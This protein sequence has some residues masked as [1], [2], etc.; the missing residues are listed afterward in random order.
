MSMAKREYFELSMEPE[1][2]NDAKRAYSMILE[3]GDR[4]RTIT[5][6]EV[7]ELIA[8]AIDMHVHAFPDPEID[9]GWDQIQVAR[10]ATDAGMGGVVFKA[11][12]F[13][14]A[15]TAP[16]V[17]QAVDE[18]ARSIGKEPAKV[19]GGIVLNYY[20]GG[21]NPAA[22]EMA[23]KI[24]AKV[25]WLPSH[26][27]AHHRRVMGQTGGICL[28]DDH[29]E[30][31]P[32]LKEILAMVAEHDLILDP[33]HAGTKER[34]VVI[35]AAKKA[36]VKRFIVTH[37]DW[38]VTKATIEEQAEMGRM[39][40]FMGLFMYGAVP[41]FNNPHCDPMEMIRIIKQVTPER[42]VVATDLGTAVNVHPV[43][44]MRLFI[45]ILLAC[46][47]SKPDITRMIKGNPRWLLGLDN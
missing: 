9:T 20:V 45:R 38:N 10:R 37:P 15:M 26:H 12:T 35:E 6:R 43:E 13:P 8:G 27:S 17:Q 36:G 19:Y 29:D 25:V 18:Y 44:G 3:M 30:P 33:C 39:G 41:N 21:L 24:G 23:I 14:T 2:R 28:L 34:F 11:H 31:V 40:A 7:D 4:I 16:L 47:I 42:T 5:E 32:A 22:V 1:W 46:N